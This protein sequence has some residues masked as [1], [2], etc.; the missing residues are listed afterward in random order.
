M[1]HGLSLDVRNGAWAHVR[2]GDEVDNR[3]EDQQTR[4]RLLRNMALAIHY[5]RIMPTQGE[6]VPGRTGDAE[7]YAS[8]VDADGEQTSAVLAEIRALQGEQAVAELRVA[9][10]H[11]AETKPEQ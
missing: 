8:R 4:D 10:S 7:P 9:A 3:P 2:I 1:T 5:D 11:L 6:H